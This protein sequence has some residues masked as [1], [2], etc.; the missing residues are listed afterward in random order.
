MKIQPI[1]YQDGGTALCGFLAYDDSSRAVRPGVIV[2]PEIWGLGEHAKE[3]AQRLAALGYVALAGDPYGNGQQFA[4]IQ[5]ARPVAQAV[6]DSATK[7]RARIGAAL[8]ALVKQPIVDA[9][10][11]AAIGFCMG[12][13][14]ALELARSG[15]PI[16]G[17]VAFHSGLETK[18]RAAPATV[19]ARVLV[20]TGGDDAHVPWEQVKAF[21]EE[22]RDTGVD[23]QVN[24]Y[25]GAKHGFAVPGADAHNIPGVGYSASADARSWAEMVGFLNEIFR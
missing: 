9:K 4:S 21:T 23:Y 8:A 24:V 5:D 17:A 15:A 25:G 10:R 7:V 19:K 14:F 11:V 6:R 16:R 1:E 3:R 2:M 13:S 18:E 12:G 22:M 20:C